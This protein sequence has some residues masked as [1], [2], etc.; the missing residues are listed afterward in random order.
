MSNE[1]ALAHT[2]TWTKLLAKLLMQIR[3]AIKTKIK[4]AHNHKAIKHR[5]KLISVNST[6]IYRYNDSMCGEHCVLFLLCHFHW[7]SF[8]ADVKYISCFLCVFSLAHSRSIASFFFCSKFSAIIHLLLPLF[9][10]ISSRECI[11]WLLPFTAACAYNWR[12]K[13]DVNAFKIT[14]V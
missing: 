3:E 2:H 5:E 4:I 1:R 10:H 11:Y 6:N 7:W 13:L 12:V 14:F 9:W 8:S